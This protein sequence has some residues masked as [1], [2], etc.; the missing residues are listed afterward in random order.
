MTF[1]HQRQRHRTGLCSFNWNSGDLS[2]KVQDCRIVCSIAILTLT[3]RDDRCAENSLR[4]RG[5]LSKS[6]RSFDA[7]RKSKKRKKISCFQRNTLDS[8]ALKIPSISFRSKICINRRSRDNVRLNFHKLFGSSKH[9][10]RD[11]YRWNLDFSTRITT[12]WRR[13]ETR[14]IHAR[15]RYSS[16]SCS[17]YSLKN[18]SQF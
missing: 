4:N 10:L 1:I 14:R 8:N 15:M 17:V 16:K 2:V 12:N 9:F 7:K 13:D 5:S 18:N 11:E 6:S 3:N